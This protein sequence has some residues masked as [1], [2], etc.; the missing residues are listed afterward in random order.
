MDLVHGQGRTTASVIGIYCT[1]HKVFSRK[2][3]KK[4]KAVTKGPRITW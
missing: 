4:R 2:E 1:V 3:A